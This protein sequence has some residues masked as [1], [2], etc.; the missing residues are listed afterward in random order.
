MFIQQFKYHTIY[1][2]TYRDTRPYIEKYRDTKFGHDTQP[3]F[4]L[5][6]AKKKYVC[7]VSG[8]H[9]T[10]SATSGFLQVE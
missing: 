1:R 2:D 6:I 9:K 4:V 8:H 7:L 5:F 10:K 3:Y